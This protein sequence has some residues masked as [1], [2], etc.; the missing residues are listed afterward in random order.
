MYKTG[1]SRRAALIVIVILVVGFLALAAD[2][3]NSTM[4]SIQLN[5]AAT[6]PV[7]I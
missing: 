1:C 3:A 2:A 5:S 6:F 7:D 4:R